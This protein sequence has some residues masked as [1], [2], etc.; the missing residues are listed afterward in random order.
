MPQSAD[1]LFPEAILDLY[2]V[3]EACLV[4]QIGLSRNE[5]KIAAKTLANEFWSQYAGV[6]LYVPVGRDLRLSA[7]D[8]A[9]VEAHFAGVPKSELLL[10]YGIT[11][12][13]FYAI[14]RRVAA[15]E[16]G[17]QLDL[18]NAPA[19]ADIEKS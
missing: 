19:E 7:R 5:A 10:K 11:N 12:S 14:L 6:Q 2:R 4:D 17:N 18:F 13:R 3:A 1:P 15:V 8:R 9:L 16:A